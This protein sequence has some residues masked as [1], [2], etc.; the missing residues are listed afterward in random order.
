MTESKTP[1]TQPA[2]ALSEREREK[3]QEV[4]LTL[5]TTAMNNGWDL[6]RTKQAVTELSEL[7]LGRTR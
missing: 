2:K 5:A 6:S 7:V 4:R 1:A 3:E